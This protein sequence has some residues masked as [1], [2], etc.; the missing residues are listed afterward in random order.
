MDEI[1][2]KN[3]TSAENRIREAEKRA[4]EAER[5]AADAER[6]IEKHAEESERRVPAVTQQYS[7]IPGAF[8]DDDGPS[9]PQALLA[10][11][12]DRTGTSYSTDTLPSPNTVQGFRASK[13]KERQS[14]SR[15]RELMD[16]ELPSSPIRELQTSNGKEQQDAGGGSEAMDQEPS[17]SNRIQG[18][19]TSN[20]KEQQ[21]AGGGSG[22]MDQ[23]QSPFIPAPVVRASQ[24]KGRQGR[25]RGG[26][27]T[28]GEPLS[29]GPMDEDPVGAAPSW[30][31]KE[32]QGRVRGDRPVDRAPSCDHIQPV[33]ALPARGQQVFDSSDDDEDEWQVNTKNPT[34]ESIP[35][36]PPPMT[37]SRPKGGAGS[38]LRL[39][40]K[41]SN[42]VR[43]FVTPQHDQPAQL[44][45]LLKKELS[46]HRQSALASRTSPGLA[47]ARVSFSPTPQVS[48]IALAASSSTNRVR[49][50]TQSPI[51][52]VT[53]P[54][55]YSR[56]STLAS[57][58]SRVSASP[59]PPVPHIAFEASSST[60][61][62]RVSTQ[63]PLAIDRAV[64]PTAP[65]GLPSPRTYDKR[66]TVAHESCTP[67]LQVKVEDKFDVVIE[68]LRQFRKTL[69]DL[70]TSPNTALR[71]PQRLRGSSAFGR[72]P[73]RSSNPERTVLL[74][75]LNL[76]LYY[77]ISHLQ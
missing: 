58:T 57:R 14:S 32:R 42:S 36:I 63:S 15:S 48:H 2:Q 7:S 28:N 52:I 30:K 25:V 73:R 65:G 40:P 19:R 37:F 26:G 76:L 72:T 54:Q 39:V 13:G 17:P 11:H 55:T 45:P 24:G 38:R 31:G 29:S 60:N 10:N 34:F 46:S 27:I 75:R 41:A 12:Q 64:T 20:G 49:V 69:A 6:R 43:S 21:G 47:S 22:P 62:V 66:F 74:V 56:T 61:R 67:E 4:L 44:T 3:L 1:I 77:K 5:R 59:T 68:E 18:L 71:T 51:A 16:E 35:A 53:S 23:D 50:S 70:A 33:Q 9:I 8:D